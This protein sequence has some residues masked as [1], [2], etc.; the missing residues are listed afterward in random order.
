VTRC[1]GR[2]APLYDTGFK[3]THHALMLLALAGGI[4]A[5]A[6]IATGRLFPVI[7]LALLVPALVFLLRRLRQARHRASEAERRLRVAEDDASIG[8]FEIEPER[9]SLVASGS[10]WRLIGREPITGPVPLS[11]WLGVLHP[12]EVGAARELLMR[13]PSL[14]RAEIEHRVLLPDGQAR[15]VLTR[16]RGDATSRPAR[17]RGVTVDITERR[18]A[19]LELTRT[20]AE[21]R[22]QV[23]DLRELHEL[24]ARLEAISDPATQLDEI[25]CTLVRMHGGRGGLV[26]L[27]DDNGRLRLAASKGLDDTSARSLAHLPLKAGALALCCE[28]ARRVNSPRARA[29][30]PSIRRRSS[31]T[32]ASSSA[33]SRCWSASRAPSPTGNCGSPTSAPARP[34]C[35][36]SARA[37]RP[38]RAWAMNVSA[39]C[40]M[41]PRPAS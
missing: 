36:S 3:H 38:W 37:H 21:L 33:P 14:L 19:T 31:V 39:A 24:S 7:T 13:P 5:L 2:A 29:S 9:D 25:L 15:W 28:E 17:I 11:A 18:H 20:Q 32:R 22:Q 8:V 27:C 35:S 16:V 6:W 10:F 12:S 34:P 23:E 30:A 1:I 40:S 26:L 41:P 4:G